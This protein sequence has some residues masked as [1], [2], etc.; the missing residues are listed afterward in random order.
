MW[1]ILLCAPVL[2]M[3]ISANT[4]KG[5]EL[6]WIGVW[7]VEKILGLYLAIFLLHNFLLAPL[8]IYKQKSARYFLLSAGLTIVFFV[9]QY[10]FRDDKPHDFERKPEVEI[11][12]PPRIDDDGARIKPFDPHKSEWQRPHKGKRHGHRR[13]KGD[14]PMIGPIE[15]I[16]TMS[17]VFMLGMNLAIKL[18][19]K[20]QKDKSRM[21]ELEKENLKQR[22]NYLRYQINPHFFMNTLNNIHALVD[23]DP[24]KAKTAIVE[25]SKLMRHIL[26]DGDR[27][28]ISLNEAAQFL[29]NYIR[30]MRMRY[31]DK[32][33]INVDIPPRL[34]SKGI[35]PL[36]LSV[37]AENAFKHGISYQKESRID[38][39]LRCHDDRAILFTCRNTKFAVPPAQQDNGGIGLDNVKNRLN[40][41]YGDRYQMDI[42]EDD[43]FYKIRLLLPLL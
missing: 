29:L 41:I 26:Y 17:M 21:K 8:I 14:R 37:F 31:T 2:V 4:S 15:L 5:I 10:V 11:G 38:I 9:G 27:Q 25:L 20:S 42:K 18:Y 30:L 19:F 43:R 40:L 28:T 24:E 35:A 16:N 6:D 7:H 12:L 23:I 39:T 13:R 32:V 34:S 36:I 3:L 22:L 1:T 33:K